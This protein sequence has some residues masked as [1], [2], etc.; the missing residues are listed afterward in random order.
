V[1]GGNVLVGEPGGDIEHDDGT[2]AMD[3][4]K[5]QEER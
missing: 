5:Q 3:A 4:E 2:L 1:P